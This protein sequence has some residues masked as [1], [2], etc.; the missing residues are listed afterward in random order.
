MTDLVIIQRPLIK[1]PTELEKSARASEIR[2]CPEPDED[3]RRRS[4][5]RY[6]AV[7]PR[8]LV[9]TS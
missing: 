7:R 5:T 4:S 1:D 2:Q 9:T 8:T 3:A 6:P